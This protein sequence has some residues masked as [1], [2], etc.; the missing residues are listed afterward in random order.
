MTQQTLTP[1]HKG[2]LLGGGLD[3]GSF[4]MVYIGAVI[5]GWMD[6]SGEEFTPASLLYVL[7]PVVTGILTGGFWGHMAGRVVEQENPRRYLKVFGYGLIAYVIAAFLVG[8]ALVVGTAIE[9]GQAN[10]DGSI[11]GDS[12]KI[13]VIG[14]LILS[15]LFVPVVAVLTYLLE[16]WTRK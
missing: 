14:A 6:G 10:P 9:E 5:S 13:G 8:T 7:V 2:A 11:V 4:G 3:F 15:P 1:L 12:I 16:R